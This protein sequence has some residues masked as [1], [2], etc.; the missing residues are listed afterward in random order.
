MTMSLQKSARQIIIIIPVHPWTQFLFNLQGPGIIN[1][2]IV[3]PATNG[4]GWAAMVECTQQKE[5]N[6][7]FCIIY[8]GN[9]GGKNYVYMK[10]KDKGHALT[11][12]LS[13]GELG[14]VSESWFPENPLEKG[15]RPSH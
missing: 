6:G 7:P 9:C 14:T 15:V 2:Y 13:S 12:S 4:D 3:D 10:E 8:R 11:T 1:R 5:R